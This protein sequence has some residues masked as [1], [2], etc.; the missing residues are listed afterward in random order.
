MINTVFV[1]S[2]LSRNKMATATFVTG[3]TS[4]VVMTTMSS[5]YCRGNAY[6]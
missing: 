2:E 1:D 3:V 6:V 5:D 4:D